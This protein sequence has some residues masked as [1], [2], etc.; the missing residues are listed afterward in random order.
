LLPEGAFGLGGVGGD[1]NAELDDEVATATVLEREALRADA[2]TLTVL[3]PRGDFDIE[4]AVESGDRDFGAEDGF[5][6]GEE[7]GME[8]I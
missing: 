5:P 6:R 2:E 4:G 1:F 3:G 7:E 8:K